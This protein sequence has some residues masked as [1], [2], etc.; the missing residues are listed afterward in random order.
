MPLEPGPRG[1]LLVHGIGQGERPGQFLARVVHGL[2][3]ALLHSPGRDAAGRLYYPR[4]DREVDPRARPPV[5]RLH[6]T[7][8]DGS[9]TTWVFVE[10]FWGDAFPPPRLGPVVR[11]LL[12]QGLF[13]ARSLWQ[14]LLHDPANDRCRGPGGSD[15]PWRAGPLLRL[16]LR[17]EMALLALGLL[18]GALLLPPLLLALLPL[19][20]LP[21][22]GPLSWLHPLDPFLTGVL[23][24]VHRYLY[25]GVWSASARGVV[26]GALLD[27]LRGRYGPLQGLTILA[28]SMG[29][30]LAYDALTEGGPVARA[31]ARLGPQAPPITLLA[32]GSALNPA[33]AMARRG[34][35][36]ARL[37]FRRPLAP[38]LREGPFLW[39]DVHARLDPV[40]AGPPS[41]DLLRLA[42]L[43]PAQ[44][45]ACRVVNRDTP[46]GDHSAYWENWALV[47]PLIARAVNGGHPP[48][49]EADTTPEKASLYTRRLALRVALRWLSLALGL[50]ALGLAVAALWGSLP[51]SPSLAV[52]ASALLPRLLAPSMAPEVAG[53][54]GCRRNE[55]S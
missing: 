9:H 39:L 14:G 29:C 19:S 10:A 32:L 25:H 28:H 8:P 27:M 42:G 36:Y 34:N 26:E 37:R 21:R 13:L 44:V 51:L 50:S 24:D 17:L 23:G 22:V 45:M 30:V 1:V 55:S 47:M 2:A 33:L 15:V 3:E 46:L 41:P 12:R 6:I 53:I 52:G 54:P 38:A 49:P 4:L 31:L 35:L 5:A 43:A 16:S 18:L 48:W 40:P 11:W 7:A 20:R